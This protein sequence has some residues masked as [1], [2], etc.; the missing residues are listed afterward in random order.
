MNLMIVAEADPHKGVILVQIAEPPL[1]Q[2]TP[3]SLARV[4]GVVA[5]NS[6]TGRDLA[7]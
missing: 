4:L 3:S 1:A 5:R 2:T 6:L 7:N